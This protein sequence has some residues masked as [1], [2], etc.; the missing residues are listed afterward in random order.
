MVPHAP[1]Y[2]HFTNIVVQPAASSSHNFSTNPSHVVT[3]FHGCKLDRDQQ[4]V[5]IRLCKQSCL[6]VTDDDALDAAAASCGPA[7]A[8]QPSV[9][10]L[11]PLLMA[12]QAARGLD[13]A[14][15]EQ[16]DRL[17]SGELT[18]TSVGVFELIDKSVRDFHIRSRLL[19]GG[20]MCPAPVCKTAFGLRVSAPL[21]TAQVA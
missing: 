15:E 7:A 11:P 1:Y 17:H 2:A 5:L 8:V 18:S 16:H 13:P 20:R 19:S 10:G 3:T 6:L 4:T 14:Q 12:R 21:L 9:E